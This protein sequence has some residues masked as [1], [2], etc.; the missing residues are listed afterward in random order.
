MTA[1]TIPFAEISAQ[2]HSIKRVTLRC[3][4]RAI[5]ARECEIDFHAATDELQLAAKHDGILEI[6]NQDELQDILAEIFTHHGVNGATTKNY[7]ND[8]VP[9][10]VRDAIIEDRKNREEKRDG[11]IMKCRADH[12]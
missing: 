2:V 9:D 1:T 6:F 10:Y 4:A 7:H 3:E 8:W 12:F 5:L 11:M